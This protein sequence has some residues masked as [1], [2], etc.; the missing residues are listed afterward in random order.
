MGSIKNIVVIH[1]YNRF[2][3]STKHFHYFRVLEQQLGDQTHPL[4]TIIIQR[5]GE[6]DGAIQ[7]R[8]QFLGQR[9]ILRPI[10]CCPGVSVGIEVVHEVYEVICEVSRSVDV[11]DI[12]S[13]CLLNITSLTSGVDGR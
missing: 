2:S 1:T 11:E 5:D 7:E 4:L 8:Q 9:T 6:W 13:V 10:E 3:L 12:R